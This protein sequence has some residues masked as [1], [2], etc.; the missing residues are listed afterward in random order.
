MMPTIEELQAQRNE[1]QRILTTT[2]DRNKFR[3][4]NK[5]KE[6]D[7]QIAGMTPQADVTPGATTAPAGLFLG[8]SA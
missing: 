2:S 4:E 6:I 8:R 7:T 1:Y 5:I 3:L